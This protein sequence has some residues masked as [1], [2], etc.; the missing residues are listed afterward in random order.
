VAAGAP[1]ALAALAFAMAAAWARVV[2]AAGV[3]PAALPV[4]NARVVDSAG[5]LSATAGARLSRR[6]AAH[7]Q[8][9][10]QQVVVVTLQSLAGR[11]IEEVGVELGRRAGVGRR[12][13][14]DGALFIVA[15]QERRVRIEVGY[16]LEGVLTDAACATIINA[17]VLPPLRSGD[18]EAGIVAGVEG[19]L[20]TLGGTL[21]ADP[22]AEPRAGRGERQPQ[23]MGWLFFV[24]W[25]SLMVVAM[26]SRGRRGHGLRGMLPLL[27]SA[28][29]GGRGGRHGG[30]GG[31]GGGFR[32]SGGGFGGGGASGS[33]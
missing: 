10:G 20:A 13:L 25:A 1:A 11:T 21:D 27:L 24:V 26:T 6:L 15:P 22:A 9:T 19:I 8:A 3:E 31:P 18:F 33:W 2:A 29:V 32:G 14:D 5:L 28:A 23:A 7:E 30:F 17:L 12:G 16:G 4:L